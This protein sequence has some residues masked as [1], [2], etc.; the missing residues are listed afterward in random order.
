MIKRKYADIHKT[1]EQIE[2]Y[3]SKKLM[4]WSHHWSQEHGLEP[5]IKDKIITRIDTIRE[6]E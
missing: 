6:Y 3:I 4:A 1:V 2:R 5:C